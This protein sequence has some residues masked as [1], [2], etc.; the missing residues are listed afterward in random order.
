MEERE[1]TQPGSGANSGDKAVP[2]VGEL[3]ARA[4]D[5]QQV[6]QSALADVAFARHRAQI[7]VASKSKFAIESFAKS[8][9][10]LK[11]AL[12]AA[13]A[14]QT[15]DLMA[16][17]AGMELALE[18]LKMAFEKHGLMEVCPPR[19]AHYDPLKHRASAQIETEPAT[20]VVTHTEIKGYTINGR[21]IRPATVQVAPGTKH[22]SRQI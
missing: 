14:L 21:L 7:D 16:F 5:L 12:E 9:L 3:E 15:E 10:P 19:G 13:L 18:Q 17:H 22:S 1:V 20:W 11:D 4:A 8:L 2:L 6:L